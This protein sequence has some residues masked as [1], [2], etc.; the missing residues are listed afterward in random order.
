MKRLLESEA[1]ARI[2]GAR[3][4]AEGAFEISWLAPGPYHIE[5]RRGASR[6]ARR[7]LEVGPAGAN[8]GRWN[9]ADG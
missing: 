8:L 1:W 7:A 6:V 3:P 9:P 2:A 5:L 4:D